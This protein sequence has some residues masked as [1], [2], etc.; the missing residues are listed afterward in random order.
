MKEEN[1]DSFTA[2]LFLMS[3]TVWSVGVEVPTNIA[4]KYVGIG[5]K[6][7]VCTLNDNAAYQCALMPQGDGRYF[8]NVNAELQKKLSL[9]IDEL[10]YVSIEPDNSKYGLPMPEE[11]QAIFDIDDQADSVF[12]ALTAG[13]QRT[14]LHLIGKPKSSEIR[15]KKAISVVDYLKEVN[16]K[17]DFKELNEAIKRGNK[18]QF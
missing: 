12:H 17:L 2:V 3:S 18:K 13:K 1:K 5:E 15:I 11:L 4:A 9:K 10:V 8:L 16:G 7:V 14:L 6:R